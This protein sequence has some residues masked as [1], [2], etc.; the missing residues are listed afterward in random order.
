MLYRVFHLPPL[1]LALWALLA[2]LAVSGALIFRTRWAKDRPTHRYAMLSLV[3]HVLLLCIATSVPVLSGPRGEPDCGPVRLTIVMHDTEQPQSATPVAPS[4][5]PAAPIEDPLEPI[6]EKLPELAPPELM[7]VAESSPPPPAESQ[8]TEP[9]VA[10]APALDQ[11]PTETVE[12]QPA[13]EQVAADLPTQESPEASDWT[14]Q[15]PIVPSPRQDPWPEPVALQ[16]PRPFE[17]RSAEGRLARVVAA[18]G[19]QATED[20]VAAGLAWLAAA[21]SPDGRWDAARWGAG[22]EELV[23]NE[24]RGGAGGDGDTGVSALALLAFMGAGQTH[25]EGAHAD[26]VRRGLEF[27]LNSQDNHGSLSGIARPFARTY[28]H[29]MATFALAEALALT[30]DD[31]LATSVQHAVDH[32]LSLQNRSTGGWRYNPGDPGD[33]SQMGWVIMALRSAELAGVRVPATAWTGIERFLRSVARGQNGGLAAYRPDVRDPGRSMTAEAL[34]C[35]QILGDKRDDMRDLEAIA[36]VLGELPGDSAKSN[37]YYWYYATL[38]L[39]HQRNSDNAALSA[40][41]VWNQRMQQSVLATQV[42]DG[43]TAGS[44]PPNTLWGGYGGRV[45]STAMATMCLE[46]YYRYE[47]AGDRSDPWIAARPSDGLVR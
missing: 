44:W 36:A 9:Q 45:Y 1:S 11:Q 12:Q 28:C 41:K 40:W 21:Q 35:R 26:N 16:T 34:Y 3:A 23:Y 8:A 20:A 22:R 32:L 29:S 19:S 15:R 42:Q 7:A 25:R 47:P 6:A 2:V 5:D 18:G 43:G 33:T 46:V 24:N 30:D 37:L 4:E 31:R 13:A 39:H 38:A 17:A 14:P 10:D 27:L